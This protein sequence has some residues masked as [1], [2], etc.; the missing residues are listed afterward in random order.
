MSDPNIILYNFSIPKLFTG[1]FAV[2]NSIY[3]DDKRNSYY[4]VDFYDTDN[5]SILLMDNRIPTN[6]VF[7][8]NSVDASDNPTP[9]TPFD[10]RGVAIQMSLPN[11]IGD[12]STQFILSGKNNLMSLATRHVYT[13]ENFTISR[14]NPIPVVA[15]PDLSGIIQDLSGQIPDLTKV[16][17]L[18]GAL[19]LIGL[20]DE[21]DEDY[22]YGDYMDGDDEELPMTTD[23][24]TLY[25]NNTTNRGGGGGNIIE[26]LAF[27]EQKGGTYLKCSPVNKDIDKSKHTEVIALDTREGRTYGTINILQLM[28]GGVLF[29]IL[30]FILMMIIPPVNTFINGKYK[31]SPV[32]EIKSPDI[33]KIIF[34]NNVSVLFAIFFALW[35]FIFIFAYEYSGKALQQILLIFIYIG[36]VGFG[37]SLYANYLPTQ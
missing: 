1:S 20:A 15:M 29:L 34:N 36:L 24:F 10:R 19:A 5:K 26:G 14:V 8:I 12:T 28:V 37:S 21:E 23:N 7:Y 18:S 4:I 32:F 2:N 25:G 3:V 17:D 33:L 22:D 27:E 30:A 35:T 16:K 9:T 11:A 13:T 31:A 6:N